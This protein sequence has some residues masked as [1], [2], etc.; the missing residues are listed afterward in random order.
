[1]HLNNQSDSSK[2][3]YYF[4]LFIMEETTGDS[5][6][7][8][9]TFFLFSMFL[10][11]FQNLSFSIQF[12]KECILRDSRHQGPGC[13][14]KPTKINKSRHSQPNEGKHTTISKTL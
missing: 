11:F 5:L 13:G 4:F 9:T 3:D 1:M 12:I 7:T 8:I 10:L 2:W 14:P 6:I